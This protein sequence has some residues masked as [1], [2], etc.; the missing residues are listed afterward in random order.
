MKKP[1]L[2]WL[3]LAMP[4]LLTGCPDGGGG[5]GIGEGLPPF[6][7]QAYLKAS[8]AEAQDLFAHSMAIDGDTL[9]V[10][11]PNEDSNAVTVGGNATNNLA[12]NSGAA[13][14]FVRSGAT[15]IQQG[16]LK[17]SN[18]EAGDN[19]G[20]SVAISG[21]TVA[22]GAPGEASNGTGP[23]NNSAAS[24]GAVYVFTRSAGAWTQQAYLKASIVDAGDSFGTAVAVSGDTLVVGATGEDSNATGVGGTQLDNSAA[25]SGAVYVFAR[26]AGLWT[27]QAYVKASNTGAGDQFGA[28]VALDVDTV[29]VGSRFEDSNAA[30]VGGNQN[31]ES[32]SNAGAVYIFTRSGAAWAQ[33]AYLKASTTDAGDEFGSSV[34]LSGDTLA[35]GARREDSNG[36]GVNPGPGAESDNSLGESGAVYIFNRSSGAWTQQAYIKASNAG[37]GD[38]FGT[39]VALDANT[40]AVGAPLE[41]SNATG[42]NGSQTN[43][44]ATNSGSVYVYTRV[45]S[46]WTQGTY[47]KAANTDSDDQFGASLSLSDGTLTAGAPGEDSSA[48]GIGGSQ[49]DNSASAAG[50]A[51]VF[52]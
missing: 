22:V 33:Q 29:A 15:W 11:A 42:I 38:E 1:H 41:D 25:D 14:V 13:Y 39:S 28:T 52:R 10:G 40:L 44:A 37:A 43:N 30:G 27:E 47:L 34:A 50:A 48:T 45:G 23:A 35:I 51:Y 5:G 46:T 8:N 6:V 32:S 9:V 24:A 16:Y 18:S 7:L 12:A 2:G 17:A 3:M 19:F 49:V 4:L 26:S 31:D 20:M 36:V 21:D